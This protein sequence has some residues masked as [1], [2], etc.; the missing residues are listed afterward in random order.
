MTDCATTFNDTGRS[1]HRK[2]ADMRKK[3]SIAFGSTNH[4]SD[5]Q[6]EGIK[7]RDS[8]N[9]T[10]HSQKFAEG[11]WYHVRRRKEAGWESE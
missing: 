6:N 3:A 10:T 11:S 2:T 4:N 7:G 9:R 5:Y 1:K 8:S